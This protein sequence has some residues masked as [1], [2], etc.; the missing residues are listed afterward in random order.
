VR[1]LQAAKKKYAKCGPDP[2]DAD[3]QEELVFS[4]RQGK[5]DIAT[6][7]ATNHAGTK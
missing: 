5:T 1:A 6:I 2:A 3:V 4:A 7:T